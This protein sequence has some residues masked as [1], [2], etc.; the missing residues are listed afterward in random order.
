MEIA[1]IGTGNIG[2]A[3]A[4]H[5]HAAGHRLHLGARDPSDAKAEA[6]AQ[7]V[8]ARVSGVEES[9]RVADVVALAI[10]GPVLLETVAQLADGL[11]G[12]TVLV[13]AN[14]MSRSSPNLAQAVAQAAPGARVIRAFNTIAAETLAAGSADG[15]P[16]DMF[17]V[18]AEDADEVA[19]TLI[20]DCGLRPIRV[21]D[22]DKGDLIDD[23]FAL[24]A[25]LVFGG[26]H[27]R[28]TTFALKGG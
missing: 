7:E 18:A 25:A 14:D 26:G 24:W 2:G 11:G 12:K 28:G 17:Y 5:W 16:V 22:V 8:D 9:A 15:E 27:G 19:R 20:S 4:R 10:P 23:L 3:L 1:I 6:L 13:P 21:G